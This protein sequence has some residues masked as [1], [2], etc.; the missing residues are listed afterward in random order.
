MTLANGVGPILPGGGDDGLGDVP[1]DSADVV[2]SISKAAF[3]THAR[4]SWSLLVENQ[5]ET[6]APHSWYGFAT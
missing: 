4:S 2:E 1:G 3:L 6:P 5:W